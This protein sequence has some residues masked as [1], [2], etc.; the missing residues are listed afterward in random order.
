[1]A[2]QNCQKSVHEYIKQKKK[3]I[4]IGIYDQGKKQRGNN[5]SDP[6]F[7]MLI[8]KLDNLKDDYRDVII[9]KDVSGYS[10]KEIAGIMRK[11]IMMKEKTGNWK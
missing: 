9:L 6:D 7:R 1:M 11:A 4:G 5:E 10:M 8:E 3:N 2:F